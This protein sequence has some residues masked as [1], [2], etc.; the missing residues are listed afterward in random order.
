MEEISLTGADSDL[1]K[2]DC[3]GGAGCAILFRMKRIAFLPAVLAAVLAAGCASAP[4]G[5]RDPGVEPFTPLATD[6][7]NVLA[8]EIREPEVVL[9]AHVDVDMRS[10]PRYTLFRY[11]PVVFRTDGGDGVLR[12]HAVA[13]EEIHTTMATLRDAIRRRH[14]G[15]TVGVVLFFGGEPVGTPGRPLG[16]RE[17]AALSEVVSSHLLPMFEAS[18]IPFAW[19]VPRETRF[20]PIRPQ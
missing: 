18:D 16:E 19:I 10:D 1:R 11:T 17:T 13:P 2:S 15:G 9:A 14:E 6:A 4:S 5:G 12:L 7:R 8:E 20:Y 3:G